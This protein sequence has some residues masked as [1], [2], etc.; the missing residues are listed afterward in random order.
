M[1]PESLLPCSQGP[2]LVPILRQVHP[3]QTF[4][5]YFPKTRKY[6]PFFFSYVRPNPRLYVTFCN[7]IFFY[8][9]VIPTLNPQAG[10]PHFV[11]RPRLL[12]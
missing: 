2:L 6:I 1:E 9:E 10:G 7:G 5:P 3:V 11:G 4:R 8:Y 12:I